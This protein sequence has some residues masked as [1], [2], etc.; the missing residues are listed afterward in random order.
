MIGIRP[1]HRLQDDLATFNLQ[2]KWVPKKSTAKG[3]GGNAKVHGVIL[4]PISIAQVSGILET[5]VVDGE[6]PLLLPVGLL[7]VLG[8]VIDVEDS[9][10]YL[11]K[12]QCHVP[13]TELPSGHLT[14]AV[15]DFD[16]KGFEVPSEAGKLEE[17][18]LKPACDLT[19]DAFVTAML[20][21]STSPRNSSSQR[22][23]QA[24]HGSAILCD[25]AAADEAPS[26]PRNN[27]RARA[28]GDDGASKGAQCKRAL[29][30]WR[31]ILDKLITLVILTS[32]QGAVRDWCP[33][34]LGSEQSYLVEDKP[35]TVEDTYAYLIQEAKLLAPLKSKE[36]PMI[37][38]SNCIHHKTDLKAGGNGSAS[39]IVCRACHSRSE[40]NYR[41]ADLKKELKM[42]PAE[43][44]VKIRAP[45]VPKASSLTVHHEEL[46][47]SS[48]Q[49][50]AEVAS[51]GELREWCWS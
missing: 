9:S 34:L 43:N 6:V 33:A 10:M 2:G 13:L 18:Q 12:H 15:T 48:S 36:K 38:A 17:F 50:M 20:A 22:R 24:C 31:V 42:R 29:R 23:P 44:P 37:A 39:W 21:L 47:A 1:L 46:A 7:K 27:S 16:G 8:A 26:R 11:K 32:L 4:L 3:V 14:V 30:N 35:E 51:M 19:K 5:T 28:L 40:M 45:P 49:A 41:A 25:D